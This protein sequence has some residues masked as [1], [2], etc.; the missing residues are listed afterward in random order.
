ML[1]Y[2]SGSCCH[3]VHDKNEKQQTID[4]DAD[5][6]WREDALRAVLGNTKQSDDTKKQTDDDKQKC[7]QIQYHW[8]TDLFASDE[9]KKNNNWAYPTQ[10]R[11]LMCEGFGF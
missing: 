5:N 11:R 7:Y 10:F 3:E 8:R 4:D 2:R 6:S 1:L 9:K